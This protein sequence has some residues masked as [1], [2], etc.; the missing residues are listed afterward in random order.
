MESKELWMLFKAKLLAKYNNM[1]ITN[2]VRSSSVK[3]LRVETG[4][5]YIV[6]AHEYLIEHITKYSDLFLPILQEYDPSITT[7][8]ISFSRSAFEEEIA[9]EKHHFEERQR[10][11][12]EERKRQSFRRAVDYSNIPWNTRETHRFDKLQV[13]EGNK[14]A[15]Q[16]AREYAGIND[17][18]FTVPRHHF[19]TFMGRSGTGKTHLAIA[20]GWEYLESGETAIVYFQTE[21]LLDSFRR[22]YSDDSKGTFD[23]IMRK[24]EEADLLILDDIGAESGTEWARAKLDQIIDFRYIRELDTVFTTNESVQ[25]LG[26]RISSRIAEGNIVKLATPDYRVIK[27]QR[28]EMKTYKGIDNDN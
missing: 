15:I 20:I 27:A 26:M 24:V 28:R 3:L 12:E 16:L 22:S 19:L 9:E 14:K 13:A 11:A 1:P 5:A 2:I 23:D 10:I 21:E 25:R 18:K 8:E 4:K 17:G 6:T 7:L